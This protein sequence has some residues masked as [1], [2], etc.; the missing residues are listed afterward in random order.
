MTYAQEASTQFH[1]LI[2]ALVSFTE[3]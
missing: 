1:R 3:I 2:L